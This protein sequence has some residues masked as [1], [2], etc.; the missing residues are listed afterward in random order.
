MP[1]FNVKIQK[2]D[3]S[4]EDLIVESK[5]PL[6]AKNFLRRR[7]L[8]PIEVQIS[9][10]N[11][12]SGTEPREREYIAT[13]ELKNGTRTTIDIA[14][15]S[16]TAARR[17]LRR[18]GKRVLKLEPARKQNNSIKTAKKTITTSIFSE[19]KIK[20]EIAQ[21]KDQCCNPL[22]NSLNVLQE[23]KRKPY[24]QANSQRLWMQ[25]FQSFEDWT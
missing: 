23:S 11:T 16:E 22:N 12:S 25:E 19:P 17:E 9:K 5:S 8:K 7:G 6:N 15:I 13:C 14:A 18:R 1:T 24:G 2:A 20:T 3:G 21:K 10:S 4:T